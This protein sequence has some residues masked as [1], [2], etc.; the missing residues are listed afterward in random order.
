M[1]VGSVTLKKNE[2]NM[3]GISIGGGAPYC[4]VLYVVQV[5]DKSPAGDSGLILPGDELTAVNERS[6]KGFTKA[7]V[8]KRI[9]G[10][11]VRESL[12]IGSLIIL[13]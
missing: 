13:S 10:V 11:G 9:Q 12:K 1:S 4:P 8:A 3:V 2:R 5:F 7:Q 6:V